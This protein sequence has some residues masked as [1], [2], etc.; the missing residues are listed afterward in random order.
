MYFLLID[1]IVELV[2]VAS[3]LADNL[4]SD[5]ALCAFVSG[6]IDA[7]CAPG[8]K[9]FQDIEIGQI[10]SRGRRSRRLERSRR[11]GKRFV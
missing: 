6:K 10:P 3:S 4:E 9:Q 1:D 2:L 7:C 8:P 5:K 11:R